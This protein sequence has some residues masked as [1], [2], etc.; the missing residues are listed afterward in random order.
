M[1][2]Q[3]YIEHGYKISSLIDDAELQRAEADVEAA[4]ITPIVGAAIV[5][6]AVK[7]K[8]VANL[9]FLLLTQRTIFVT[10]A[11]AKTK[12]GYESIDAETNAKLRE[13]ATSCHASLEALRAC[14]GANAGAEV[15]DICRLYFKSNYFYLK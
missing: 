15:L 2:K 11:G 12:N 4:Y 13:A 8:A 3:W 5:P 6:D 10:R 1:Q 14:D 9:T 7:Q